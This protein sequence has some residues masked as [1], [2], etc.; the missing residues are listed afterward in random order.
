MSYA[1]CKWYCFSFTISVVYEILFI[2]SFKSTPYRT[3][4]FQITDMQSKYLHWN[5]FHVVLWIFAYKLFFAYQCLLTIYN[6]KFEG[7]FHGKSTSG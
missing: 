3:N 5:C 6:F 2:Y 1:D 4:M 7:A